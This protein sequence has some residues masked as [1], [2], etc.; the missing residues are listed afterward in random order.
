MHQAHGGD[1]F[2]DPTTCLI[3]YEAWRRAVEA[4]EAAMEQIASTLNGAVEGTIAGNILESNL[5]P[6]VAAMN[7]SGAGGGSGQE[8][9]VKDTGE[10]RP[11][12]QIPADEDTEEQHAQE[13]D[14]Q[15]RASQDHD[16]HHHQD[17]PDQHLHDQHPNQHTGADDGH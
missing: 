2:P 12:A 16:A 9:P 10:D 1:Q 17:M 6:N 11:V 13:R 14:F 15:E 5:D 7:W 8:E 3:C 4:E